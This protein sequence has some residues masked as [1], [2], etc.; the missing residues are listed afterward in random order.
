MAKGK[1]VVQE[2]V[3]ALQLLTREPDELSPVK[4]YS[5]SYVGAAD[6]WSHKKGHKEAGSQ[7]KRR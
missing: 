5:A 6:S 1:E 4:Q 2:P 7:V 3:R